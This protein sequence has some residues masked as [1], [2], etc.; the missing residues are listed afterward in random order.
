MRNTSRGGTKRGSPRQVPRSPPL[1]HTT[2][3]ERGNA[4][5]LL[6]TYSVF[7]SENSTSNGEKSNYLYKINYCIE[8][9]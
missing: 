3:T 8:K 4:F 5:K 2:A 7:P 9:K 6:Q 1:R